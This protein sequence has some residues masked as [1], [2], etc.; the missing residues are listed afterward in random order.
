[1]A[2]PKQTEKGERRRALLVAAAAGLL[3]VFVEVLATLAEPFLRGSSR[4]RSG[5][6]GVGLGLA[7][8]RGLTPGGRLGAAA[9]VTGLTLLSE[10]VSFT[11]VI[12]STPVLR[13]I[14]AWGRP[15]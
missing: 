4:A 7:I 12:E 6:T 2:A 3:A 8:V 15:R 5:H 13:E 11:R 1:M 14:D 10:R 9:L